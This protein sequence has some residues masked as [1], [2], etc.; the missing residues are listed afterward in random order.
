[1][2]ARWADEF[3]RDPDVVSAI[4]ARLSPQKDW[5]RNVTTRR[6]LEILRDDPK[7]TAAHLDW[8][9]RKLR[10][11]DP[12]LD[13][14]REIPEGTP[15]SEL[16]D[17]QAAF[18]IRAQNE[19]FRDRKVY[20]HEGNRV[21]GTLAWQ[22]FDVISS[23]VR[24]AR[25]GDYATID[26]EL[27]GQ[28]KVRNFYNNHVEPDSPHAD[29]TIDTHAGVVA[30]LMPYGGNSGAIVDLFGGVSHAG[31]GYQG[32][33]YLYADAYRLAARELGKQPRE[34]QSVT[35]EKIRQ[36]LSPAGKRKPWAEELIGN[37]LDAA[38]DGELSRDRARQ[39]ILQAYTELS[40]PRTRAQYPA[41]LQ[42]YLP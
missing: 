1:M 38:D 35:W 11:D 16:D 29:V 6:M 10:P 24:I 4:N 15:L 3:D 13:T 37:I 25:K 14:L 8:A 26:R 17:Q 33:Y 31:S 27:G 7:W 23:A 21:P 5:F 39:L 28:H 40:S 12:R 2:S 20:D 36:L 32:T 22:S 41:E 9:T 42:P 30:T 34:V 18:L 19:L